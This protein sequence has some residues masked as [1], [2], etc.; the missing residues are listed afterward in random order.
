MA[1]AVQVF[2]VIHF[3][4]MGLSHMLRPGLWVAFFEW[5]RS[6]GAPGVFIHG[7]I[8]LGFGSFIA[9]FHNVWSGIPMLLTVVGYLYLFKALLCFVFPNTQ[10]RT[11]A[12]V[13]S[14]RTRELVAAG[15]VF[16][17]VASALLYSLLRP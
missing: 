12:R 1:H 4:L 17:F 14:N 9:A 5:L 7:F 16:L 13:S 6:L 11:L 2:A 10:I 15:A 3:S 8:S